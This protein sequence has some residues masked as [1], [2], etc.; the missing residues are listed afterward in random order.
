MHL[1]ILR[2]S[3]SLQMSGAL[4]NLLF[5]YFSNLYWTICKKKKKKVEIFIWAIGLYGAIP[6]AMYYILQP[7]NYGYKELWPIILV[8]IF[9]EN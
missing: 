8:Q 6:R 2:L 4:Q 1:Q 9:H 3:W 5:P 7:L